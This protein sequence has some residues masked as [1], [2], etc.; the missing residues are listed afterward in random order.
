MSCSGHLAL[1]CG[2]LLH[3][4]WRHTPASRTMKFMTTF[5]KDTDW[6][7]QRTVWMSCECCLFLKQMLKLGL[8]VLQVTISVEHNLVC[9]NHKLICNS[10]FSSMSQLTWKLHGKLEHL[11]VVLLLKLCT[12]HTFQF[13]LFQFVS[14]IANNISPQKL[15]LFWNWTAICRHLQKWF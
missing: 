8:I 10:L 4:A 12:E 13:L 3:A 15:H 1:P 5:L 11:E 9:L 14:S 7:S 6:S 2:R